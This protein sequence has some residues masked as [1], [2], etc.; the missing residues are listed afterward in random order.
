M[1]KVFVFLVSL[2]IITSGCTRRE[3]APNDQKPDSL[4]SVTVVLK[5]DGM[6]CTGCENTISNAIMQLG[7]VSNV[8]A[9]HESGRVEVTFDT[10]LVDLK[11]ISQAITDK[12]YTVEGQAV[13]PKP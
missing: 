11:S 5:V 7:G 8:R 3:N 4:K 6:S 9:D 10:T 12:G 13:Q 1:R 2:V